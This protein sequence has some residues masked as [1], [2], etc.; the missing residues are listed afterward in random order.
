MSDASY[1]RSDILQGS[2]LV[3]E[4]RPWP[5]GFGLLI[6]AAASAGLWGAI[7]WGI[8]RFLG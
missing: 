1:Q 4:P 5:I 6:G 7:A 2:A 8:A 3:R